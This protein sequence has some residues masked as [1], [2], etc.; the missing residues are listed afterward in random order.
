MSTSPSACSGPIYAV[1][2]SEFIGMCIS[3]VVSGRDCFL[4]ITHPF[5][6]DIPPPPSSTEFPEPLGE[7]FEDL[8]H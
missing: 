5:G 1:T 2:V 3:S 8:N 7:G 6:S 4:G